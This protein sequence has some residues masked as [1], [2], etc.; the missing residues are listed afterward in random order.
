M[1]SN[2]LLLGFF[3]LIGL[4][5]TAQVSFLG[6]YGVEKLREPQLKSLSKLELGFDF[7]LND[8]W[9]LGLGYGLSQPKTVYGNK[10]F[11]YCDSFE[12]IGFGQPICVG[13][14]STVNSDYSIRYKKSDFFVSVVRM[15]EI[16]KHRFYAGLGIGVDR[17]TREE[18]VFD[19]LLNRYKKEEAWAFQTQFLFRYQHKFFKTEFLSAFA[20]LRLSFFYSP[21][22]NCED[23]DCDNFLTYA[24]NSQFNFMVGLALK[25]N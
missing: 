23:A 10:D 14:D 8:K 13:N 6:K 22:P 21:Q 15:K 18:K 25:V 2:F 3:V 20:E 7:Q 16:E 11:Y 9:V 1:K 19:P 24:F 12:Y 4:H 17:F 5:S